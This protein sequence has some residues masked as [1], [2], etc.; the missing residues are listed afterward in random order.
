MADVSSSHSLLLEAWRMTE[1]VNGVRSVLPIT[2][3]PDWARHADRLAKFGAS[4]IFERVIEYQVMQ[5]NRRAKSVSPMTGQWY[6]SG[7]ASSALVAK[8]G[9]FAAGNRPHMN[10]TP[11]SSV[12]YFTSED[13]GLCPNALMCGDGRGAAR[14]PVPL[15]SVWIIPWN[16]C[17]ARRF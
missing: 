5:W 6:F 13:L 3:G 17:V 16:S 7:G 10:V 12:P 8:S 2:T 1:A 9:I 11:D 4:P 15:R 14:P